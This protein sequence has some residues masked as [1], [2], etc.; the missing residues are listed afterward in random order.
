M[1]L[2]IFDLGQDIFV[3]HILPKLNCSDVEQLQLVDNPRINQ[4]L[5]SNLASKYLYSISFNDKPINKP[6]IS[7]NT[8]YNSRSSATFFNWGAKNDSRLGYSYP[9]TINKPQNLSCFNSSKIRQITSNGFSFQILLQNGDLYITGHNWNNHSESNSPGPNTQGADAPSANIINRNDYI[10]AT[11]SENGRRRARFSRPNTNALVGTFHNIQRLLREGELSAGI[12]STPRGFP[13]L[14]QEI[15][16]LKENLELEDEEIFVISDDEDDSIVD[17]SRVNKAKIPKNPTFN[18]IKNHPKFV[19]VSGGHTHF[20]A[21]DDRN[22]IWTWDTSNAQIG[23]KV[24]FIDQSN[25]DIL[26]NKDH[27]RN[28]ISSIKA[29]WNLSGCYIENV[30]LAVWNRRKGLDSSNWTNQKSVQTN[31]TII[32]NSLNAIDYILG[33]GFLI[34]I[35][36]EGFL[37]RLNLNWST[38]NEF[39]FSTENLTYPLSTFNDLLNSN[40]K[41]N[42]KSKF[43]KL[44]GN[45]THFGAITN[46]D[47]VYLSSKEKSN[48]S[49]IVAYNNKKSPR[50]FISNLSDDENIK[51]IK[52]YIDIFPELQK[53]GCNTVVS[54]DYHH[55]ALLDNGDMYSWGRES[56]KCGCLGLETAD[57]IKLKVIEAIKA[58]DP[59]KN[60]RNITASE[61]DEYYVSD[62]YS[63]TVFKPIKIQVD[64]HYKSLAVTASGWHSG[65]LLG[66]FT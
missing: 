56:E 21:L 33:E 61:L 50:I 51:L 19:Q 62:R 15:A 3:N 37:N 6:E 35:D 9:L 65:A 63:V 55:L 59:S 60:W 43:I 32:P 49:S 54:G 39:I 41:L 25:N 53:N 16:T 45:Y 66:K 1:P 4:L 2:T 12:S 23:V 64:E 5:S 29:G 52:K 11:F 13:T 44:F 31:F 7:W 18:P 17:P 10:K 20:I 28:F 34:Y 26:V 48:L 8:L 38:E 24:N 30:G 57:E 27:S 58:K 36:P 22:N 46:Y 42:K 47:D 14:Q 40:K